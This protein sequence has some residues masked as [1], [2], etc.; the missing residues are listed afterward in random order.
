MMAPF[1][2]DPMTYWRARDVVFFANLR[3]PNI[4]KPEIFCE[5]AH[6]HAPDAPVLAHFSVLA[7]LAEFHVV[8]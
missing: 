7:V 5:H 3:E 8:S 1:D 4:R 6:R 2:V